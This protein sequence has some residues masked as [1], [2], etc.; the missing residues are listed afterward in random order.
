[1][2]ILLSGGGTLGPVAPLLAIY[3]KYKIHDKKSEFIWVGTNDGPERSIVK[4]YNIPFFVIIS[5]KW[6]RYF[7]FFNLIDTGKIFIGFLQ[8]VV[9][10][11]RQRP[12]LL[13]SAGGFVSVPLHYAAFVLGIPTWA[14]QQDVQVGLANQLMAKVAV[15]ITTALRDS[16]KFFNVKKTEWIGNPVRDLTVANIDLSYNKFQ[17]DKNNPVIFAFGGGTGSDR[18]NHLIVEMLPHLPNDYQ[19]I[20]LTGPERDSSYAQGALKTHRNYKVYKFFTT[21][22]KDAYAVADV[23]IGRGG[24][25]TI[26]ELAS[27]KKAAVL[28]PMPDTHQE[29]NVRMLADNKAAIILDQRKVNGIDLGYIVKDLINNFKVRNY[30]GERLYKI[31]PPAESEKIINII[32][33]LAE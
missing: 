16:T 14:H 19:V 20:H 22:M 25:V 27:L 15:K 29:I 4:N 11:I 9:F 24:F 17:L 18:L 2:K 5:G 12:D 32:H 30:L 8:S 6:R 1:M 10:L 7:S 3:E 26:T 33:K 23:V 28:L 13:I 31:L 21:E